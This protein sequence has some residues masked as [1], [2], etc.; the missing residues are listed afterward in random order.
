M[1][2]V[3]ILIVLVGFGCTGSLTPEQR[4]KARKAIEEG[5][6]K[7]ITPAELTEFALKEGK[8]IALAVNGKDPF[9][10]NAAFIDS[11]AKANEVKLFA[12]KP[13]IKN[14]SAEELQVAQAYAEQGDVSGL[15]DNVQ[16]TGDSLLYTIPVGNERP[17]GSK[18]FSHAIA[19]KM[20]VK[21]LVLSI[22]SKY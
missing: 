20:A 7:R 17:D 18:S 16:K 2:N 12:L 14:L 19:V 22:E 9:F 8:R 11:V 13:G 1:K 6:I 4:E 3:W 10:N 5:Q 15:P 21:R